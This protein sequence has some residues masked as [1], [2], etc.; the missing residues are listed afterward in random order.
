MILRSCMNAE[1]VAGHCTQRYAAKGSFTQATSMPEQI[2]CKLWLQKDRRS[3]APW[4]STI[5]AQWL[6]LVDLI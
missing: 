4:N 1:I 2:G 3:R 5:G 6:K